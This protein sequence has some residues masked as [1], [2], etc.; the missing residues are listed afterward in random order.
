MKKDSWLQSEQ[1]FNKDQAS[2]REGTSVWFDSQQVPLVRKQKVGL[3]QQGQSQAGR[4][5]GTHTHSLN[6]FQD[7][8]GCASHKCSL[9][10][11]VCVCVE[12]CVC[13]VL[14]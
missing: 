2:F 4:G 5:R 11:C 6:S 14:L 8:S 9:T 13:K 12:S 7:H 10:L 1:T 3:D